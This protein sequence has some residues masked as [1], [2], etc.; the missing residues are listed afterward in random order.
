MAT[1]ALPKLYI[2]ILVPSIFI[3]RL[4]RSTYDHVSASQKT[5]HFS[6][7][8]MESR[9]HLLPEND[10]P[11]KSP[12]IICSRCRNKMIHGPFPLVGFPVIRM[13]KRADLYA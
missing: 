10:I 2:L 6:I 1:L 11:F 12:S 8:N 5:K 7:D 9:K 13:H 3:F 4:H